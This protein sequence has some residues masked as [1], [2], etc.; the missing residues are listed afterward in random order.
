[1][2]DVLRSCSICLLAFALSGCDVRVGDNGGVSVGIFEG[3]AVDEWVRTYTLPPGG[4]LDIVNSNGAIEVTGADGPLTEVRLERQAEAGSDELA[5]EALQSVQIVEDVGDDRVRVEVRRSDV[6]APG[7]WRGRPQVT[8][9][10]AVRL[11]RGLTASFRTENGGIR[12][13][14]VNGQILA[15]TTNGGI[16]GSGVSGGVTASTVNGGVQLSLDS[17]TAPVELTAVNGGVRLELAP[18]VKADVVAA[19]VNGGVSI[20][21]RLNHVGTSGQRSGRPGTSRMTA[22][23]NG[24]GPTITAQ[25]TNGGVR[26]MARDS[27]PAAALER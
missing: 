27:E 14:N 8:V 20:D 12:L 23:L 21:E 13:V 19:A 16:T 4:R 17:V 3:K 10:Y 25:T 11:P 26:I 9:R 5:R 22:T 24:G 1:M 15:A 7:G 18:D 6:E 2:V